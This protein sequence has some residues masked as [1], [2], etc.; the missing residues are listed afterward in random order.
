MTAK[1][2]NPYLLLARNILVAIGTGSLIAYTNFHVETGYWAMSIIALS[3]FLIGFLEPRRGWILALIQASIVICFYYLKPIKP[4][5]ED[6]AMFTSHIA[7]AQS[8]VFSFV[9]GALRRLYLKK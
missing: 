8:L 7:V 2:N 5:S 6:L 1:I 3:S 4:I 9:A